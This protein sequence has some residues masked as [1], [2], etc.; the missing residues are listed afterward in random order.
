MEETVRLADWVVQQ[1][2]GLRLGVFLGVLALLGLGELGRPR[3]TTVRRR[4][5][6][7]PNLAMLAIDA[8]VLRFVFPLLAV[9]VALWADSSGVGL[10]RWAGLP[11]AVA[12]VAA[13]LVLDFAIWAQHLAMHRLPWLWRMHR[14][15]HSDL[16][17]DIT[18]GVR[19]HPLEIVVSMLYKMAVVA[20]LGASVTAV[21]AFEVLLNATSLFNH[22]NLRLPD[23]LDRWLRLIVV[24]PDMHRVHHSLWQ[25]E[26]DSNY[27]FNLPWWDRLFGT[28]RAAPRDGHVA[29]RI[30]LGRFRSR[31]EQTLWL[32]LMQPAEPV[33][34]TDRVN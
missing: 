24:T 33:R 12:F 30:G 6:W 10:L 26:T 17:F 16:E 14:V 7:W 9:G 34:Q 11:A 5:R 27:G 31:R 18:T 15:H 19:F 4:G 2:P 1:E 20:L 13:L 28:Y 32:L 3:R 22:A 21:I 29:M 23:T 25:P 8:L